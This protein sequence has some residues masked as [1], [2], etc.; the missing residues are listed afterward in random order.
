MAAMMRTQIRECNRLR[1]ERA[2]PL[3]SGSALAGEAHGVERS[4]RSNREGRVTG[5]AAFDT[6]PVTLLTG[7][8]GSGKTTLLRRALSAPAFSDTAVIVNEIGAIPIDHY[9]VDF[10]EGRVPE[11]P[12]GCLCCMVREDLAQSLRTLIE[13]RGGGGI[14]RVWRVTVES[15]GAR[16]A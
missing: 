2:S 5:A 1:G 13:R 10:V 14:P 7:F 11:L 12:V 6:L 3:G 8:L 9:L 15:T 16:G 4:P